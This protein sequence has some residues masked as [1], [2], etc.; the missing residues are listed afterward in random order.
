LKKKDGAMEAGFILSMKIFQ[1]FSK[2]PRIY[3]I[4]FACFAN[5]PLFRM[6]YMRSNDVFLSVLVY[7]CLYFAF[8]STTGLRQTM[9]FVIINYIGIKFTEQRKLMP[10]L[11]LVAISYMIHRSA[12]AVVPLYFIAYKKPTPAYFICCI[13][14]I[15]VLFILRNQFTS[16][17][18]TLGGYDRY[19]KQFM[20]AGT[21]TFTVVMIAL[22][23]V[24]MMQYK[25]LIYQN[26]ENVFYL[27]STIIAVMLL[28]LTYVDPTNMR[29]VYYYAMYVMLLVPEAVASFSGKD[30]HIV[31]LLVVVLMIMLYIVKDNY[32]V[33][34]WQSGYKHIGPSV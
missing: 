5:I 16:I 7:Q 30:R 15:G 9:V 10:F 1:L 31:Y 22:L 23:F 24:C 27:N 4:A 2:S 11:M 19:A 18:A 13:G 29:V 14:V 32:Y 20:G 6:F 8:I 25:S 21:W 17:L 12:I 33:F 3:L 34:F 26:K 28:P